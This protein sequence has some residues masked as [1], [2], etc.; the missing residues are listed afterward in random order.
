M[1]YH[2]SHLSLKKRTEDKTSSIPELLQN[3]D[4]WIAAAT[5][6]VYHKITFIYRNQN[7][8]ISKSNHSALC[9]CFWLL[10]TNL[11]LFPGSLST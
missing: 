5:P 11:G 2:L 6:P 4:L 3:K 7:L 9:T 10:D 1:F 8:Y